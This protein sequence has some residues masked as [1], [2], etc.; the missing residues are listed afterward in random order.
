MKELISEF[1]LGGEEQKGET[2][3]VRV[4]FTSWFDVK[5]IAKVGWFGL[6]EEIMSNGIILNCVH[7]STY[8][9]C[10]NLNA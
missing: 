6:L 4:S 3:V 10:I 2:E 9:Q 8:S 7:C 1:K 5:E